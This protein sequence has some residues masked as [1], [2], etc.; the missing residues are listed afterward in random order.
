M[1]ERILEDL[2]KIRMEQPFGDLS[3]IDTGSLDG[4]VVGDLDRPYIFESQHPAGR[5]R[6]DHRR[7]ADPWLI[8][9]I[10]GENLRVSSFCKIIGFFI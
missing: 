5:M 4:S 9:E 2:L 8:L 7:D 1:E 10:L 6:P 3:P